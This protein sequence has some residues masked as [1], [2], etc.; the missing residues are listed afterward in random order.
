MLLNKLPFLSTYL[1]I[2]QFKEKKTFI[3][4]IFLKKVIFYLPMDENLIKA[5]R[6][7]FSF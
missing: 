2:I 4:S 5:P 6:T 3:K 1:I 7:H